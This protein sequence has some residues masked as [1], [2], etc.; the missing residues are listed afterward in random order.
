RW[1]PRA[2]ASS[3]ST[4]SIAPQRN[5]GCRARPLT[6]A[7]ASCKHGPC[8]TRPRRAGGTMARVTRPPPAEPRAPDVVDMLPPSGITAVRARPNPRVLGL[9]ALGHLVV[10]M[11]QG[12]IPPLLP[13]LR[14][15]FGLSYAASGVILLVASVTSSVVQPVFGY[16]A[17]RAPR[18]WLLPWAVFLSAT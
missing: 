5:A 9:L 11:N 7:C 3:V 15:A 10:D 18:R 4:A 1:Y 2:L 12:A 16:L 13:F 6:R 8:C 17:D 14:T